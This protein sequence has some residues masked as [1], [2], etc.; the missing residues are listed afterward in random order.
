MSNEIFT[1]HKCIGQTLGGIGCKVSV[2]DVNYNIWLREQLITLISRV[3]ELKNV[4]FV[5]SKSDTLAAIE[6]VLRQSPPAWQNISKLLQASN[7]MLD[8]HEISVDA[9]LPLQ[10]PLRSLPMDVPLVYVLVSTKVTSTIHIGHCKNLY[11]QI[12]K[13]NNLVPSPSDEYVYGNET[14]QLGTPQ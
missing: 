10:L 9:N 3:H 6:K 12:L 4:Y 14:E 13:I 7:P 1:I 11:A 5:G 2:A 8:E